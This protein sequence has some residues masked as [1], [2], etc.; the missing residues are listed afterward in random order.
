MGQ[1]TGIWIENWNSPHAGHE[2]YS[3][4]VW[5]QGMRYLDFRRR[6]AAHQTVQP[7][8]QVSP[9]AE[10]HRKNGGDQ[11]NV[12]YPLQSWCRHAFP[13]KD[14]GIG[15]FFANISCRLGGY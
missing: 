9:A 13:P 8:G 14:M 10:R 3:Q 2:I 12:R 4:A 5:E 6:C 11:N 7:L 15:P 1:Q